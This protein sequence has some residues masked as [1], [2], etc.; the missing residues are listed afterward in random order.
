MEENLFNA[1]TITFSS[2]S[3]IASDGYTIYVTLSG[4]TSL[5]LLPSTAIDGLLVFVNGI[6]ISVRT[7]YVENPSGSSVQKS[8]VILKTYV[9]IKSTDTVQVKHVYDNLTDNSTT[10]IPDL[11][12]FTITVNNSA[13]NKY[14]DPGEWNSGLNNGEVVI[15][16]DTGFF[17]DATD[18]FKKELTFPFAEVILDTKPPEGV[19]IIN[20]SISTGGID[21]RTFAAYAPFDA[22]TSGYIDRKLALNSSAI[23]GWQFVSST[24]QRITSFVIQLKSSQL[25]S[26]SPAIGNQTGRV[27]VSL[28]SNT[29]GDIPN[30]QIVEL[31]VI[32]YDTITSTYQDF[33]LTPSTTLTLSA[34]TT[35]WIILSFETIIKSG[36]TSSGTIDLLVKN[37][38]TLNYAVFE[39]SAWRRLAQ[40][41]TG[42]L[43]LVGTTTDGDAISSDIMA[44]DIIGK[45]LYQATN[46][47]GSTNSSQY[48]KIGAG[49]AYFLNM[50]LT[51][52][53]T[54][55]LYPLVQ[56]ID[57]GATADTAKSFIVE[58]KL[59]PKSSWQTLYY[60]SASTTTTDFVRYK[61][62][63]PTRFSNIRI[64]Y[65]G[66]LL[67]N[68]EAGTLTIAG[69]D[70][71][72][73]VVEVQ[74]SHFSDFRD[75]DEFE[76]VNTR[77]WA[78]FTE[79]ASV[80]DWNVTNQARLWEK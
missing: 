45:N 49:D 29:T 23:E 61:F 30:S 37:N 80:Y 68:I 10:A 75:A 48:E 42:Y 2:S 46:F 50:Y 53:S 76:N 7:A 38:S 47:G 65:R 25:S 15:G 58:T 59:T 62:N 24:E 31:G 44:Q 77:A 71:W 26:P 28:Y 43:K 3:Y 41:Q 67:A 56:A 35:Y 57:I 4:V 19:V 63:T 12:L 70:E 36:V 16:S 69:I 55:S 27:I 39:S 32:Q 11:S 64:G 34:Q 13:N 78:P 22:S 1:F 20:E 66:D 9:R 17:T 74:A 6:P 52:D 14:F 40:K 73:D 51:P 79:G 5:P 33:S 18:L 60:N 8:T 21:I 72:S 54:T